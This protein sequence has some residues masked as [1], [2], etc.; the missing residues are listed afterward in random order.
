MSYQQE[1]VREWVWAY[2]T[3]HPDQ[4]WLNSPY[5]SWEKNPHYTGKPGHHPEDDRDLCDAD[6]TPVADCKGESCKSH[7]R[8]CWQ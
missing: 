1:Q 2:G 4:E 7:K 3:E 6:G 8:C 5:D